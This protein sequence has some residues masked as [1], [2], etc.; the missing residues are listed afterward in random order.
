VAYTRS[1]FTPWPL[2]GGPP[3]SSNHILI[4][5]ARGE[6]ERYS[7]VS[8]LTLN[9]DDVIQV[10]TA[11]GAG[12]GDPLQRDPALVQN[13][14]KNGYITPEQAARDYGLDKPFL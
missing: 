3:G 14:L 8:G 4:R 12:W 6:K 11:T 5:R 13:D 9:M 10:M 2:E 1:K 7:V